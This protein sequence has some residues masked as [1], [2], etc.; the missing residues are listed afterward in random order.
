MS[1]SVEQIIIFISA[2]ITLLLLV[3]AVN[4]RYFRD[5]IVVFLFKSML[6]M[7]VGSPVVEL[8]LLEY[9][10]RLL[11]KYYDTS[12]LFELWVFPVLCILYNQVTRERG[13]WPIIY[14][15]LLFSAGITAIEYPLEVYTDLIHYIHWTWLTTFC[16]L[17]L[18]FL[19]SRIFIA[20]FRWGCNHFGQK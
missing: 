11:P 7:I 17:T 8:K 19:A 4:W 6:D 14:Y 10:V 1:F 20:F 3:F 16:T 13:F 15:A 12:I 5:W 18:T 2:V 9:P